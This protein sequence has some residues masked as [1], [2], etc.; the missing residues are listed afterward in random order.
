MGQSPKGIVAR[1]LSTTRW[2]PHTSAPLQASKSLIFE[3]ILTE[4]ERGWLSNTTQELLAFS[5]QA[6][7]LVLSTSTFTEDLLKLQHV[8]WEELLSSMKHVT[9]NVIGARTPG[10]AMFVLVRHKHADMHKE[11]TYGAE[12]FMPC[13]PLEGYQHQFSAAPEVWAEHLLNLKVIPL[14]SLRFVLDCVCVGA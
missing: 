2:S 6:R 12:H 3:T 13:M 8:T 11:G 14:L 7:F 4:L 1:A 5:Q 10:R 9:I